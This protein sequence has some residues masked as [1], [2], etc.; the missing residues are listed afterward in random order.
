M[1][2][3]TNTKLVQRNRRIAHF[4]FFFTMAVLIG[5]F[6]FS[7]VQLA[8][9]NS[10]TVA[11]ALLVP[12]LVL[13]LAI[14]STLFS[15]R[16]TNLW[17]RRPRPEDAIREGLKGL[18]KRSTLYN[19]YHFPARH[20]LIS[21]QGVFAITTRFQE[22]RFAVEGDTWKTYSGGFASFLRFFRRDGIGNPS[23][24]AQQAAAHVQKLMQPFAPDIE[25][26]PMVIFV[27][28]RA[29]VEMLNPNIPVLYTDSKR[30]PNLTDYMRDLA[31]QQGE[32]EPV[33]ET[34]KKGGAKSKGGDKPPNGVM[35]FD[36]EE[37]A[38]AFEEATLP[39]LE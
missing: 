22:G 7:N 30:T 39:P 16:M 27:D 11:L 26:K 31:R 29:Q 34:K 20:V 28:P 35:A 36:P 24:D 38:V 2:I 13:P 19:Y 12:Y 8:N 32:K 5:S 4:S 14:I 33:K 17:I 25:V 37:L 1:L 23:A 21:P 15:V 10:S 6:I 3:E 9:Q 18:S